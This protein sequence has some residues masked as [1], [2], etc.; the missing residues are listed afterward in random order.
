M[1]FP[2][3]VPYYLMPESKLILEK[4]KSVIFNCFNSQL[5]GWGLSK[6]DA[7]QCQH[8]AERGLLYTQGSYSS[9][10]CYPDLWAFQHNSTDN[11]ERLKQLQ[12]RQRNR[13]AAIR[14]KRRMGG[15]AEAGIPKLLRIYT[16]SNHSLQAQPRPKM[17]ALQSRPATG[18][19][20]P[21]A[22][23]SSETCLNQ[24]WKQSFHVQHG[25]PHIWQADAEGNVLLS[26]RSEN[27]EEPRR[28]R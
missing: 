16:Q 23:H 11:W 17:P 20:V 25:E 5:L 7:G 6:Q 4:V 9:L 19:G 28:V 14:H 1:Q 3:T 8:R 27:A 10:S 26:L 13:W 22:A 24:L 12:H 21:L 18:T 15:T 2:K